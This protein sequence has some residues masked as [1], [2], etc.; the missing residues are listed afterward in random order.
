MSLSVNNRTADHP[1]D[2]R[3]L[4]RWSPR[5]FTGEPIP[6]EVLMSL[7]EAARWLRWCSDLQPWRFVY[8]LRDSPDWERLLSVLIEYNQAWVR[9]ASAPAVL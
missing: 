3:F 9:R 1:I 6:T 7:F 8:V 5:A 4:A 2:E